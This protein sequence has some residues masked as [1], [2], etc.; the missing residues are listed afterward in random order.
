VTEQPKKIEF[1]SK[2]APRGGVA[3]TTVAMSQFLPP[4]SFAKYCG[5]EKLPNVRKNRKKIYM[6]LNMHPYFQ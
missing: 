1:A 6:E 4:L 2:S 3:T 5:G